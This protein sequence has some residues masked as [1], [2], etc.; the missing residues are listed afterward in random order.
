[1]N[2]IKPQRAFLKNL[3][4]LDDFL[5]EIKNID[6]IENKIIENIREEKIEIYDIRFENVIF[7]NIEIV[8][9][10]LEK[11]TFINVEFKNRNFSNT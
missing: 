7:N 9:S 11:N 2:I 6:L 10:T 1:M 8:S 3:S 4:A 5:E